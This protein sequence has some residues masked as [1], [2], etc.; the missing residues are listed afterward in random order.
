MALTR[1]F[2]KTIKARA[3][4]DPA[5]RRALVEE[6]TATLG[7]GN[8]FADLGLPDAEGL[9]IK[10]NLVR[11]LRQLMTTHKLTRRAAAKRLSITQSDLCSLLEGHT[12]GYSVER[13]RKMVVALAGAGFVIGRDSF[14]KICA[15][16]G[17]KLTAQMKKRF[18]EFD[19]KGLSPAERRREI[20]K[21]YAKKKG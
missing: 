15:V 1:D 8:I 10:A 2:K 18:A 6:A 21:A 17:I 14:E 13:L 19:R 4:R 9:L 20:I 11:E 16:E 5:F 12:R 7:S 3:A